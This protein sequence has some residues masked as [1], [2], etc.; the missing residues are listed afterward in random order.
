MKY[1][2]RTC[3]TTGKENFYNT[4]RYQCKTCWN[5]RTGDAGKEKVRSLK[6][7]YGGK[8]TRCGYDKCFDALEFHH[9]D[10]N[11]KEFHIGERRGL[12]IDALRVELNKCI[13]VCRNC[14]TELHFEMKDKD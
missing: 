11:T 3:P 4:A 12:N 13:L 10:P 7:E 9:T 14:H 5:K 2:C 6:T 1:Q 8:C